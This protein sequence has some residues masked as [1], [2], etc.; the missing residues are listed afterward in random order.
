VLDGQQKA[1][2]IL[3]SA[4]SVSFARSVELERCI[5]KRGQERCEMSHV[6]VYVLVRVLERSHSG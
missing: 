6:C 5:N 4:H 1:S 2:V 3:M